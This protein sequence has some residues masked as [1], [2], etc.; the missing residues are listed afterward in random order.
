VEN[1]SYETTT[2]MSTTSTTTSATSTIT[3]SQSTRFDIYQD[4]IENCIASPAK[5]PKYQI[6]QDEETTSS[7]TSLDMSTSEEVTSRSR[8]VE[9]STGTTEQTTTSSSYS[10]ITEQLSDLIFIEDIYYFNLEKELSTRPENYIKRQKE[11]GTDMR[12][13]LIDWLIEV[14]VSYNENHFSSDV[15]QLA[16]NY[17]DRFLSKMGVPK[18]KLQLLGVT[19]LMVASKM[20]DTIPPDTIQIMELTDKTYTAL[21]VRKMELMLL[22]SL[23]FDL[24]PPTSSQFTNFYLHLSQSKPDCDVTS[25]SLKL[26]TKRTYSSIFCE[27]LSDMSLLDY[28]L[29]VCWKNSNSSFGIVVIYRLILSNLLNLANKRENPYAHFKVDPKNYLK[30]IQT[31]EPELLYN[32]QSQGVFNPQLTHIAKTEFHH[33]N[34]RDCIIGILTLW[35]SVLS[36]KRV[37]NLTKKVET[38]NGWFPYLQDCY[39]FYIPENDEVVKLIEGL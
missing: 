34:L 37:N 10:E 33:N 38:M 29:S 35:R 31:K 5:A 23:K 3:N 13:I 27:L 18:L 22:E 2:S 9:S 17:M 24:Y 16:V 4:D 25:R 26:I 6:F 30:E 19:C 7:P 20:I 32:V 1:S 11:I 21:Q 15:I 14:T 39:L 12:T 28:R 8:S 36:Q